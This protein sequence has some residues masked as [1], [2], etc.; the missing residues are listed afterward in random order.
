MNNEQ[1]IMQTALAHGLYTEEEIQD[2]LMQGK[3]IPLHTFAVWKSKGLVPKK[4]EHGIET[5]LWKKRKK[6]KISKDTEESTGQAE[7]LSKGEYYLT[8]AYL[9]NRDQVVPINQGSIELCNSD[10]ML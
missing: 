5:R 8:K 6:I 9:F 3:E 7:D 10:N 4:G 2:Y 1:I